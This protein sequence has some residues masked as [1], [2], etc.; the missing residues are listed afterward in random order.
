MRN[1]HYKAIITSHYRCPSDLMTVSRDRRVLSEQYCTR[2]YDDKLLVTEKKTEIVLEFAHQNAIRIFVSTFFWFL[3]I[4]FNWVV[5]LLMSVS[6]NIFKYYLRWRE[7]YFEGAYALGLLKFTSY[8]NWNLIKYCIF[9][10]T[11]NKCLIAVT[12][13][14]LSYKKKRLSLKGRWGNKVPF[15]IILLFFFISM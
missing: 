2:W 14:V 6:S 10:L 8:W 4:F 7:L 11:C 5:K 1:G 13:F 12:V 3:K 15:R 9:V